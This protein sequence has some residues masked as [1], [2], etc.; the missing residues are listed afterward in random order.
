MRLSA[1]LSETNGKGTG[2]MRFLTPARVMLTIVA[3]LGVFVMLGFFSVMRSLDAIE[4]PQLTLQREGH[5]TRTIPM[6][7]TT[8]KPGMVVRKDDIG[9]GSWP[10]REISGDIILSERLIVGR[11]VEK[12]IS[13]TTPIHATSLRKRDDH[14]KEH[15]GVP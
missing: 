1:D 10:A 8:L 4:Q 6:A 3:M 15:V 9:R 2:T 7:V 12:E 11:V 14:S 5:E 13:S